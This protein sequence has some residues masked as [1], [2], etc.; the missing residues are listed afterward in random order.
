MGQ[1]TL[2]RVCP[3]ILLFLFM[4]ALFSLSVRRLILNAVRAMRQAFEDQQAILGYSALSI[5]GLQK[6]SARIALVAYLLGVNVGVQAFAGPA[7]PCN[8]V[9]Q[10]DEF[11]RPSRS[12]A[13]VSEDR[14]I[15]ANLSIVAFEFAPREQR[16]CIR[17]QQKR[18]LARANQLE[19]FTEGTRRV[20]PLEQRHCSRV[21][22]ADRNPAD[23]K[24]KWLFTHQY[25]S[26][27][28]H[29]RKQGPFSTVLR[30]APTT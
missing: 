22:I 14:T 7:L 3:C 5:T 16:T 12:T 10:P 18:F 29:A 19:Y 8:L 24:Q 17:S 26:C 6:A 20:V 27:P 9:R 25:H 1:V 23:A 13:F 15:N 30:Q 28:A 4:L 21:A 11:A 2:L